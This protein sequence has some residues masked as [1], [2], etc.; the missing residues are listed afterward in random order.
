[1]YV[2]SLST[3]CIL[4]LQYSHHVYV[5]T[6]EH[7]MHC[8]TSHRVLL[9]AQYLLFDDQI[10]PNIAKVNDNGHITFRRQAWGCD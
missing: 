9:Q 1:M 8:S 6:I 5:P 7:Q 3:P 2:L 4:E 10:G